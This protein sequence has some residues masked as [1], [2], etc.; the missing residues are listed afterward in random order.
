MTKTK[1]N[2]ATIEECLPFRIQ[3]YTVMEISKVQTKFD[4]VSYSL[5]RFW[6]QKYGLWVIMEGKI[7]KKIFEKFILVNFLQ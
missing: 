2:G 5:V 7:K 1:N 3:P 6:F 4:L